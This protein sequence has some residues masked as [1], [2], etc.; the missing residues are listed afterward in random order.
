[1]ESANFSFHSFVNERCV[2][3]TLHVCFSFLCIPQPFSSNQRGKMTSCAATSF[4]G[5]LFFPSLGEGKRN[6]PENETVRALDWATSVLQ[7]SQRQTVVDQHFPLI[8]K[9]AGH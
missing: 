3:L 7:C 8:M 2:L 4:P 5:F 1:M 9:M 6:D